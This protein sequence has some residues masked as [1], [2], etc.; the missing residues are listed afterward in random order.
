MAGFAWTQIS[1]LRFLHEVSQASFEEPVSQATITL[2]SSQEDELSF[3]ES[4][5]RDEG[6]DDIFRNEKNEH[7]IIVNG[8]MRK[9]YAKRPLSM[10]S[11]TFA[12]FVI[13]YY[14]KRAGQ[15]A[16]IDAQTDV[17]GESGEP[18]VG[19]ESMAP[20]F[21]KLSNNIIM[22]K[23]EDG[24]RLVP[25]LQPSHSLDDY[26]ERMLFQPWRSVEEL[27]QV[28]SGEQKIQQRQNCLALFPLGVFPRS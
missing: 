26:G 6:C 8:D 11:M 19:G 10:E 20:L 4:S 12:Q 23:R 9:L 7:Y 16:I 13:S 21:I 15:R 3:K 25:L 14:R 27:T 18:V 22:K 2:M 24:S 1:I 5:E 17:G 28:S